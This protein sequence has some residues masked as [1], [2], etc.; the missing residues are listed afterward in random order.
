MSV[1]VFKQLSYS[2][3]CL[4]NHLLK[5]PPVLNEHVVVLPYLF[6]LN[7]SLYSDHLYNTPSD[8]LNDVPGFLLPLHKMLNLEVIINS[9]DIFVLKLFI[10]CC[11]ITTLFFVSNENTR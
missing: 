3:T 11:F 9:Q 5:P 2:Q 4:N 6:R 1:L 10:I 8:H 7:L